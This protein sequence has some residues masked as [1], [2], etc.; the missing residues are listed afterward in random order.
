LSR[1]ELSALWESQMTSVE[2]LEISRL[3]NQ[4][5][6]VEAAAAGRLTESFK[7]LD[8]MGAVVGCGLGEQA[9]KLAD[10]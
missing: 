5:P 7:R 10:D 6:Q 8:Q 1:E 4:S 2:R 3:R 9:D